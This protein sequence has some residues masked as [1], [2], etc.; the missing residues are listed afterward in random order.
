[1]D[2]AE[3]IILKDLAQNVGEHARACIEGKPVKAN[4]PPASATLAGKE[5]LPEDK[6]TEDCQA[7]PPLEIVPVD[8]NPTIKSEPAEDSTTGVKQEETTEKKTAKRTARTSTNAPPRKK[9]ASSKKNEINDENLDK[10]IKELQIKVDKQK[11]VFDA[12]L[13][14]LDSAIKLKQMKKEEELK[15]VEKSIRELQNR[16]KELQETLDKN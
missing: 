5:N 13:L 9:R 14:E 4:N 7:I 12:A 11:K 15:I 1:M 16:R 10:K 6:I 3:N 8:S 2:P